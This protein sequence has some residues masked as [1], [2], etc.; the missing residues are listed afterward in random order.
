MCQS[1]GRSGRLRSILESEELF[2]EGENRVKRKHIKKVR[3]FI[4]IFLSVCVIYA[5]YHIY[6]YNAPRQTH[7]SRVSSIDLEQENL[8]GI[9][10]QQSI[11]SI[12]PSPVPNNDIELYQYY[13]LDNEMTV[14]TKRGD[15]EIIL[16]SVYS[17]PAMRTVKGI[18]TDSTQEDV[19]NAY[20]PSFYK[21]GEQGAVILGYVDKINHQSLEFW[22]YH[23]KVNMI[24][25][26]IDSVKM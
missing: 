26:S 14:A 13:T 7:Y 24:R 1:I 11:R 16:I 10:L 18:A 15:D 3:T 8:E 19:L 22:L 5:V 2:K 12:S 9:Q 17:N 6:L 21:R 4:L 23:N 20:G 25:Y